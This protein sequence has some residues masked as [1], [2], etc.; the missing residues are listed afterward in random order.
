MLSRMMGYMCTPQYAN[1]MRNSVCPI[2]AEIENDITRKKCPP[3]KMHSPGDN[4]INHD[5]AVEQQCFQ[6]EA[7]RY[8]PRP[9][10]VE[11]IASFLS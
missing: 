2:A 5:E 1:M 4:V 8:V 9:T 7:N 10:R 11:P 3:V 6:K